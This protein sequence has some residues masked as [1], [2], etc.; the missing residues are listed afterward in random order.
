MKR[1]DYVSLARLDLFSSG[2][3][4]VILNDKCTAGY[5]VVGYDSDDVQF[6]VKVRCELVDVIAPPKFKV[7]DEVL[8]KAFG[9]LHVLTMKSKYYST[10]FEEWWYYA[11]NIDGTRCH[12]REE[13]F[14]SGE[15]E[16][17]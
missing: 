10:H 17:A 2:A 5:V 12:T 13:N 3:F 8:C 7:G 15:P 11:T 9:G 14:Y 6:R 1:G 4:G 16:T